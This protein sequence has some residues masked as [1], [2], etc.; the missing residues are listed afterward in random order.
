MEAVDWVDDRLVLVGNGMTP[1]NF[2]VAM[3]LI[4]ASWVVAILLIAAFVKLIF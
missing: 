1:G 4:L 2:T 3:S